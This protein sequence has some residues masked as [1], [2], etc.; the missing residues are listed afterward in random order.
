MD[1][2]IIFDS[3]KEKLHYIKNKIEEY[4]YQLDLELKDN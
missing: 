1:D 2:M 4:L 3:D